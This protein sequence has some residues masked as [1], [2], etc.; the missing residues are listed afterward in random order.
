[1]ADLENLFEM[2]CD[3]FQRLLT[4]EKMT[5]SDR[6]LLVEFLKDN[7]VSCVGMNNKKVKNI[8][9][10]LPFSEDVENNIAIN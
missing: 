10:N 2:L 1:M 4:D 7:G 8:A 9:D 5:A 3:D 6:K